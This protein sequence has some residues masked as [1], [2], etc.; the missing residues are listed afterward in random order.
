MGG[1]ELLI[2]ENG[3]SKCQ[4]VI[5]NRAGRQ[6]RYAA[7]QLQHFLF[8]IGSC[9]I[10][11]IEATAE[12]ENRVWENSIILFEDQN[13]GPEEFCLQTKITTNYSY[14]GLPRGVVYS[15][16]FTGRLSGL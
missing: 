1:V 10:P 3:R 11:V 9:R 13:L 12:D 2:S 5:A 4:I 15:V 6:V 16:Y 7:S 8:E 14:Q